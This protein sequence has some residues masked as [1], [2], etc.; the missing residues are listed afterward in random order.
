M[1]SLFRCVGSWLPSLDVASRITGL[2]IQSVIVYNG[3]LIPPTKM[4]PW[5]SWLRWI[6]PLYYG[7]EGL[8]SNEFYNLQ[9]QCETP[10]LVP[11][12]PRATTQYQGC[13]IQ[14]STPGSAIVDGA[15][16]IKSEYDYSRS[17]LWRNFGI[18]CAMFLFFVC[19]TAIGLESQKPN[20]GGG[21]MTIF[22]RG[23]APKSIEEALTKGT[24]P[25][26]EESGKAG[27][28]NLSDEG[29][30]RGSDA[31]ETA[32]RGLARNETVF[33][34]SGVNYTIPYE[35]NERK[36]LQD[37]QGFVRPGRL[38]ALMGASGLCN[39]SFLEISH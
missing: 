19:F 12:G 1:Y 20:K 8:I 16:Y 30:S 17:H 6:N 11:Q 5:L 32:A 14:G 38:T 31:D 9:I 3:Y 13:T 35:G 2:I 28:V 23:E 33:T 29:D 4:K 39:G 36:L 24:V 7:F 26:D 15:Q 18:L 21:A 34:W 27:A 22:K 37:Q 25:E 10:F